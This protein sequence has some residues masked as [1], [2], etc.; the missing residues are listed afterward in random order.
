MI[1]RLLGAVAALVLLG[2]LALYVM[3]TGAFVDTP[4]AGEPEARAVSSAVTVERSMAIAHAAR[5][6]GVARPKQILFG[7]LHVHTTFSFDAFQMSLPMAGGD[8]ARTRWPTPATTRAT[9]PGSTSGRSTTTASRSPRAAGARPSTRSA[10]ATRW[11][12]SAT[13]ARPRLLPRLGVDASGHRAREPLGPQERDR[14][15]PRGRQDPRPAD[16][17]RDAA[18][19]AVGAGGVRPTEP[20]LLGLLALD[21]DPGGGHDFAK[22]MAETVAIPDCPA[23]VPVRDL[24]LDCRE[25]APGTPEILFDKLDDWGLDTMVIPHGTTWGFYTPLGSSWDKQLTATMHDPKRQTIVEVF[26]GHGN[27]EEYRPFREVILGDDGSRTCPEPQRDGYLPSCWR[28]GEII[29]ARCLG[30][31]PGGRVRVSARAGGAPAL[32]GR[33]LQRRRHRGARHHGGRLAGR[34]PVPRLLPALLQLP[35]AQLGAVHDGPRAPAT[36]PTRCASDFGFIAASDNHSARPG[37]GYKEVART[38]VHRAALRQLREH[39][40]RS[41]AADKEPR[42]ESKE[43]DAANIDRPPSSSSRPSAR[44]RLLL[45]ERR[46]RRRARRRPRPRRDLGGDGAQGGLRHQRSAHPALVRPAERAGP[47][48]QPARWAARWSSPRAR[49]SRCARSAP[50]S[51][52]PAAR[53]TPATRSAPERLDR[54]CQGECYHPGDARRPI[55]RIEVVRIRTQESAGEEIAP[56]VEDPWRVI[57]LLRRSG[58]LPGRLHRPGVRDEGPRRPL[59]RARHRGLEP[60]RGGRSAGLQLRRRRPLHERR[61]VLLPAGP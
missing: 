54:L 29:E 21:R 60:R 48:G 37:T 22:F 30:R 25:A 4:H 3:G 50:S 45:P 38:D 53:P 5:D 28:A 42:A 16:H 41:R 8:G 26:S 40:A 7:D 19:P 36:A 56:L 59:L 44:R 52:S 13:N 20:L 23:D 34:R 43:V 6:A 51:R 49:S 18:G 47:G 2:M 35:A 55:T 57:R 58:R 9:A 33:R 24:P 39:A 46:A 27:S 14:P 31:G 32:R 10:S 17:R 1:V 11:P 15:R 61:S 12:A